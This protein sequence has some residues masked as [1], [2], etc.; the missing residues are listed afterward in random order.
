MCVHVFSIFEEFSHVFKISEIFF[1]PVAKVELL[2][3]FSM[4]PFTDASFKKC[5]TMMSRN[6]LG[7]G[8][9]RNGSAC[10]QHGWPLRVHLY[11][12]HRHLYMKT[13]L[14]SSF[15]LCSDA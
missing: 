7:L 15:T 9:L 8:P 6:A 11:G 10:Q 14:A 4:A 3:C 12:P 1:C 13:E 5:F 2:D